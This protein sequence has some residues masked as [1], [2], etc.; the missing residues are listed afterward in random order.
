[1]S[2]HNA[3]AVID[4]MHMR[5]VV[6]SREYGGMLADLQQLIE[7][8]EGLEE[9]A[10]VSHRKELLSLYGY[11]PTAT[12]DKPFAYADGVAIIPV[13]GLLVNRFSWSWG[14]ITGYNFIRNQIEAAINDPDVKLIV[15]DMNSCGG[16]AAGCFELCEDIFAWSKIKDI[17]SVV[18]S[19]CYSGAY[20]V[21]AATNR[22]YVTPSGGAGSIGAYTMHISVAGAL[23]I[24][25]VVVTLIQ[26]GDHK[27][28][29]NPYENLPRDVQQ[30]IQANVENTRTIFVEAIARFRG[31]DEKVIRDTEG[32]SYRADQAL[33]L[34]LIDAV[35]PPAKALQA[36]YDEGEPPGSNSPEDGEDNQEQVDM[37]TA[38]AKPGAAAQPVEKTA[39]QIAADQAAEKT[40]KE[41][42]DRELASSAANTAQTAAASARTEERARVS[43][44]MG[45]EEAKGR[46]GLAQHFAMETDMTPD[47][48]QAAL[49]KAPVAKV[50]A[51]SGNA[52][53]E[54][55]DNGR[56][57][58][59][60]AG[61]DADPQGGAKVSKADGI[62]AAQSAATGRPIPKK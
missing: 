56:N 47:Q 11:S 60:E 45:C 30:N 1:M 2:I 35:Q 55:M 19:N 6:I 23:K 62:I 34:G 38:A 54:A 46:E 14:F 16:E 26:A 57:P 15:L 29:G 27:T 49:K 58:E 53:Q 43:A 48:A 24:A 36:F 17:I 61:R 39:E 10:A 59:I 22:I 44:I 8:D 28:D 25:G 21:A 7:V 42:R 3:R 37:S 40:A 33:K 31:M 50:E 13:H 52:F 51:A 5:E 4:R 32:R 18:D 41:Q 9:A 12:E 20:A